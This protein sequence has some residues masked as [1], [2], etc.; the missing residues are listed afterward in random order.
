MGGGAQEEMPSG[1][2]KVSLIQQPREHELTAGFSEEAQVGSQ[3]QKA[4]L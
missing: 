3:K 2:K 1:E 4:V